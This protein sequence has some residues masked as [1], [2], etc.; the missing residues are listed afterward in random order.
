[1]MLTVYSKICHCYT[2]Q[3]NSEIYHIQHVMND[4]PLIHYSTGP[5]HSI[6]L[7][8]LEDDKGGISCTN[9]KS[10]DFADIQHQF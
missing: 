7:S 2:A 6:I 10:K 1:M 5:I 4:S 3:S 8:I 9:Y